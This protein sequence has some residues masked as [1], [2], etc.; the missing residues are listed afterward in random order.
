MK[1]INF[2]SFLFFFLFLFPV[3]MTAQEKEKIFASKEEAIEAFDIGTLSF[4]EPTHFSGFIEISGEERLVNFSYPIFVK[5]E[6]VGGIF[7]VV[8]KPGIEFV[9]KNEKIIRRWDCGNKIFEVFFPP[10]VTEIPQNFEK[11]DLLELEAQVKALSKKID[12]RKKVPIIPSS[13]GFKFWHSSWPLLIGGVILGITSYLLFWN[14]SRP[15]E[16]DT[17]PTGPEVKTLGSLKL[18][19]G[20]KL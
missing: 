3:T 8:Q 14:D 18:S 13:N 12:N 5:M 16:V 10:P 9:E 15:L 19:F 1:N 7:W 6:V 11:K 4:Y 2:L 17:G 20:F